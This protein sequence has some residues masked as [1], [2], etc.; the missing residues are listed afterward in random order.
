MLGCLLSV[1]TS[2][3]ACGWAEKLHQ[4]SKALHALDIRILSMAAVSQEDGY[5][6][7]FNLYGI[8]LEDRKVKMHLVDAG[9]FSSLFGENLEPRALFACREEKR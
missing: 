1:L 2:R 7:Q 4:P 3:N 9:P 8:C 6:H 5:Y